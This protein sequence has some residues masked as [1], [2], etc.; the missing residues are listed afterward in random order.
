MAVD[1][2]G[3]IRMTMKKP[4]I[5]TFGELY[6]VKLNYKKPDGYWVYGHEEDVVIEVQHGVN[7]KDNHDE[8]E[9][10]ARRRFPGCRVVCVTYA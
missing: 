9:A 8:A 6:I 4:K 10:E 7:E 1:V 5:A 2:S 3:G